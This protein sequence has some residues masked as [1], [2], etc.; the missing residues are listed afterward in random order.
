METS[1]DKRKNEIVEEQNTQN[2]IIVENV[3]ELIN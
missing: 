3:Q 1:T 2:I